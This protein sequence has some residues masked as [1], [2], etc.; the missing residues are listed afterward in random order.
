ML[1]RALLLAAGLL[2][3]A[4]PT[5]AGQE[6]RPAEPIPLD[7][8]AFGLAPA[9]TVPVLAPRF[10]G[11]KAQEELAEVPSEDRLVRNPRNAAIRSFLIPGW[12]QLYTGHP[13]RAAG[14]AAAEA[15]F[16]WLG[17]RAQQRAVDKRAEIRHARAAFFA[18]PPEGAPEDSLGLEQAFQQ[19]DQART[20]QSELKDI[21]G[22]RQDW[23]A[24]S[25][26]SVIF[27]AV[28]AYAAAQLDPIRLDVDPKSRRVRAGLRLPVGARPPGP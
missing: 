1:S 4:A 15:G 2:V 3:A 20:L 12:G 27:A 5:V 19:T 11:G 24:Y 14:F 6:V 22:R 7:S 28:D 17:Y 23:Y 18:D 25:V 10:R 16:F 8:L 21:E 13:L 26:L 9:D